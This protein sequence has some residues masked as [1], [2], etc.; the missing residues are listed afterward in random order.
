MS[1][2]TRDSAENVP[3]L[4]RIVIREGLDESWSSWFEGMRI[5]LEHEQDGTSYTV[6]TGDMPDQA[7][8]HG[9]IGKIRDFNLT[10]LSVTQ[11]G[12]TAI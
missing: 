6:L 11:V 3:P 5:T 1:T 4:Y 2:E 9:V 8:L 10:L 12:R 7:A